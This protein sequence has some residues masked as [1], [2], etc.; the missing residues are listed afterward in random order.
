MRGLTYQG[1]PLPWEALLQTLEET[2]ADLV[3]RGYADH[4]LVLIHGD[5][6]E[7][8][9]LQIDGRLTGIID[10][11]FCHLDSPVL[12]VAAT[13][14]QICRVPPE[15]D[16]FDWDVVARLVRGYQRRH[17]SPAACYEI[18]PAAIRVWLLALYLWSARSLLTAG[19]ERSARGLARST[20][21][22]R[23]G[24]LARA[25]DRLLR[26]VREAAAD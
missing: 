10:F 23:L 22:S 3:H 15:F 1:T 24:L 6:N 18:V 17:P 13:I 9:L 16:A 20:G 26:V 12:D 5:V 2:P 4:P 8:N 25:G 21:R 11:D 7:S 14:W 19:N